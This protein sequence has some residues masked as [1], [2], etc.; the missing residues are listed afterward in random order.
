V[1]AERLS[2]SPRS[3]LWWTLILVGAL[4]AII[5]S[6]LLRPV[7]GSAIVVSALG[8][9]GTMLGAAVLVIVAAFWGPVVA[10]LTTRL[11]QWL[12]RISFS[13]Y[14]IHFPILIFFNAFVGP[15]LWWLSAMFTVLTS[16]GAAEL[17]TRFVEQPAHRLSLRTGKAFSSRVR[18]ILPGATTG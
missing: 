9:A 5:S 11:V 8:A 16:L 3:W 10:F 6:W 13:I 15:R 1:W 4:L 12:G 14:L 2:Q 18:T 7:L 17:F